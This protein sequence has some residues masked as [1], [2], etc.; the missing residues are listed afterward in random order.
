MNRKISGAKM[1]LVP[2]RQTGANYFPF[3]EDLKNRYIK[4]I[5]FHPSQ[6]LPDE[7]VAGVDAS[8]AL[9]SMYVTLANETGNKLLYNR[10]PLENFNY[11][12]TKGVREAIG[13]KLSLQN[14]YIECLDPA[15]VGKMVAMV[16]YYDLPTFS[17]RNRT[18][19]VMMDS[20]SIPITTGSFYNQ[21]PESERMTGKRFREILFSPCL[22]TPEYQTGVSTGAENLYVTLH[23]GSY[24]VVEN[25]PLSVL[26]QVDKLER[27]EFANII[28]DF[29]SSY[30]T[31]GGAG[32]L[33]A[34]FIGKSAFI[35]LTYE[36]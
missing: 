36:M 7:S 28:F 10:A 4:F 18:D 19:R 11:I 30:L 33:G 25:L 12:T 31:V 15:Q 32:S 8:F 6:Y 34:T 2:I 26:Y 21:F 9:G 17:A 23:K 13:A 14:C 24:N 1:V 29:Q 35:N 16:F 5:D 27:I 22:T 20:L 3:V